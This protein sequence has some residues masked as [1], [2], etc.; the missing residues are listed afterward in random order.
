MSKPFRMFM[1]KRVDGE[2]ISEIFMSDQKEELESDGWADSPAKFKDLVDD[3][4]EGM[5]LEEEK[6]TDEDKIK[7]EKRMAKHNAGQMVHNLLH[8]EAKA[9]NMLEWIEGRRAGNRD[10]RALRKQDYIDFA[11]SY[12]EEELPKTMKLKEMEEQ[13]YNRLING[14]QE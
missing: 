10:V 4:V 9:Q 11:Y 8:E 2:T 5:G 13:V 1:Y 12:W 14:D 3:I 7:L 6:E